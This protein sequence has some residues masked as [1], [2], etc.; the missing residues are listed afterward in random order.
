MDFGIRPV[1][2]AGGAVKV[3][4][5]VKIDFIIAVGK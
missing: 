2:I 4:N 5:E 1:S 3:L